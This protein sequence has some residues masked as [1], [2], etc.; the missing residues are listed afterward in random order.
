MIGTE[1]L[2]DH[3]IG[4][5]K[6]KLNSL[7][8]NVNLSNPIW[9]S[10]ASW[11]TTYSRGSNFFVMDKWGGQVY[12]TNDSPRKV[13]EKRRLLT[14]GLSWSI[15][16]SSAINDVVVDSQDNV[17]VLTVSEVRKYDSSGSNYTDY[18]SNGGGYHI[19]VDSSDNVYVASFGKVFSLTNAG[20]PRWMQSL[21]NTSGLIGSAIGAEG[22]YLFWS[23][24]ANGARKLNFKGEV[25]LDATLSFPYAGKGVVSSGEIIYFPSAKISKNLEVLARV[26]QSLGSYLSNLVIDENDNLYIASNLENTHVLMSLNNDLTKRASLLLTNTSVSGALGITKEGYLIVSDRDTVKVYDLGFSILG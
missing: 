15:T 24:P 13:L 14:G 25:V 19:Y 23:A 12:F 26:P 18:S 8:R 7:I 17:W 1:I 9:T 10:K 16:M 3:G 21:P 5:G 2:R 20:A 22:I 4:L 6:Y 11:A